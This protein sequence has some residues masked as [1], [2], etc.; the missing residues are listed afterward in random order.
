[1]F[2]EFLTHSVKSCF[3]CLQTKPVDHETLKPPL[4]SLA[5]D[6]HFPSEVLQIDLVGNLP[7]SGGYTHFLTAKDTFSK[8]LFAM[9]LRTASAPNSAKQLF[10]TFM[11][12][13]YCRKLSFRTWAPP[14][15]S[16]L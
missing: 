5:T 14:L 15:Q 4:L 2:V 12:A 10:F 1:M 11:S 3:S 13:S 8:Y 6:K 16:V 7:E 9:P